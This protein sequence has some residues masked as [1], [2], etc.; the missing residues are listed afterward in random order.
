MD[1]FEYNASPSRVLFGFASNKKLP[2]EVHRLGCQLPLL[3]ST[4]RQ[5]AQVEALYEILLAA[6]I[7]PAGTYTK[8]KMHTPTYIT[9]DAMLFM[10]Q[11]PA[12]CVVSIGGGSTIGLGKALSIRSG[13]PHICMPTTYSGSEMT[14]IL[15]ETEDGKKTT[16]SDPRILPA[17][18]IYDVDYTMSMPPALTATSGVNAMA[19]AVESL[20]AS[21]TNPILRMLALE[22]VRSLATS[23]PLIVVMPQDR[24][25]RSK[26]LYGAWLCGVALGSSSMALHHKLC[27]SL[28]GSLNLPHSETH[29]II[30][31]H[32]L[33]YNAP[34]I[35]SQLAD[36]AS[37]LPDSNGDAIHGLN[38]MLD[39]LKVKRALKD[40]G[41]T[42]E[43]VDK[44]TQI[45]MGAQ[46][47]NPR[48]LE[49]DK[50]REL[51]RRCWAGEVARADL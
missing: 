19:H 15:G 9:D 3:L 45:A 5:F 21:N 12:D 46:Y 33:S 41:M 7:Q 16:R 40:L 43:D 24:S 48:T 18:V 31:P 11:N 14:A 8:A 6:K 4:P 44:A 27:H 35:P 32:A 38:I 36:L 17:T 42:E 28:G 1:A 2:A 34:A 39:R 49:Q 29:T 13:I 47:P 50:I 23:L 25:A 30:L 10:K 51:I 26:A 22:G 37:V 20:Y